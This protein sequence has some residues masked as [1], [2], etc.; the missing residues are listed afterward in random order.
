MGGAIPA[1]LE[2]RAAGQLGRLATHRPIHPQLL[3]KR[4][5]EELTIQVTHGER[6]KD[7]MGGKENDSP[8]SGRPSTRYTTC[9]QQGTRLHQTCTTP[10]GGKGQDQ[11]YTLCPRDAGLARRGKSSHPLPHIKTRA[12]KIWTLSHQ[13][14]SIRRLLRTRTPGAMEDTP[15]DPR[16]PPDTL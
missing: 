5:D 12:E 7:D 14:G 6:T 11:I 4:N 16:Q 13:E 8:S 1:T 15:G 2:Q 9:P 10:H 3:A